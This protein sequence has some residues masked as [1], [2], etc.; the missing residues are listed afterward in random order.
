MIKPNINNETS[1]LQLVILGLPDNFGG[2]PKIED[3]YDPKSKE[4]VLSSFNI[5]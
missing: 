2:T 3:C 1:D 5:F 4:H